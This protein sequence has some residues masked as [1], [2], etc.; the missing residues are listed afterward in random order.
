MNDHQP[1]AV[2]HYVW[3][4]LDFMV[5]LSGRP[6]LLEANRASH[7]MSEYLRFHGNDRPFELVANVMNACDGPPCL[8]WRQTDRETAAEEDACFIGVRL[9]R[10]LKQPPI[11]CNVEENQSAGQTLVARGGAR[12]RPGSL[13]R[14]WYGLPTA[15][16]RAGA[17]VINPN[18]AWLAVRDKL[19]CYAALEQAHSAGA[20]GK[21]GTP[22]T[23]P[24]HFRVPRAFPVERAQQAQRLIE[25]HSR[26]FGN[27]YVL[28]PRVGWG[29]QG[30]QIGNRGQPVQPFD[31][32]YL[33]SERVIPPLVQGQFWEARVFVMD[34][35]YLGGLCHVSDTPHTNFWRGGRPAALDPGL[36]AV[37]APAA[38]EAVSLLDAAAERF[39]ASAAA[40]D[41]PL[42]RVEY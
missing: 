29:G 8:L 26:L 13:F 16:E 9:A 34:G 36:S 17:R 7:M 5:D 40:E 22:P 18:C 11:I 12:V 21:H 25:G 20:A 41:S 4:G 10:H 42:L 6:V 33:L 1:I 19:A 24:V 31:G 38:L 14:W 15:V 28:K 27:G 32:Q 3:A 30:V 2:R 39:F 23:K 37:L 35:H